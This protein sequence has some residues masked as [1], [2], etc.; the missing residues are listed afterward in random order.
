MLLRRNHDTLKYEIFIINK[1]HNTLFILF[2]VK[3]NNVLSREFV[4]NS[5]QRYANQTFN[6][7]MI[8]V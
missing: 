4:K 3:Y 7:L 2:S 8:F 5:K 1:I 6:G